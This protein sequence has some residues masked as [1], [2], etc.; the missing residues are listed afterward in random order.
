ML[1]AIHV[2]VIAGGASSGTADGL[3]MLAFAGDALFGE[4]VVVG[5]TVRSLSVMSSAAASS[6]TARYHASYAS[7]YPARGLHLGIG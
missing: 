6:R 7:P 1:D 2:A 4:V 3:A 5:I